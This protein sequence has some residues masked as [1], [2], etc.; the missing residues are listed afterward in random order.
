MRARLSLRALIGV[1][2]SH[3]GL[4]TRVKM[5]LGGSSSFSSLTL[6]AC[7]AVSPLLEFLVFFFRREPL[8]LSGLGRPLVW[9][10]S[11][12]EQIPFPPPELVI[13][14]LA[15][16]PGFPAGCARVSHEAKR[17]C[18]LRINNR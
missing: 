17:R 11:H 9:S 4:V 3:K 6:F 12:S 8:T 16:A 14:A 5:L 7:V 1:L 10:Q 18:Y 15:E 2:V 13:T